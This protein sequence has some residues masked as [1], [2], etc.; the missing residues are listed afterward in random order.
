MRRSK[1]EIIR[2]IEEIL[3]NGKSFDRPR[4]KILL[5]NK[6]PFQVQACPWSGKT[7]L[8]VAKLMFLA[9]TL[10][11]SKERICVLTHTNIAVD[12]IKKKIEKHRNKPW[13][14]EFINNVYKLFDYPNH[15]GTIQVFL[16]K[17]LWIPWY[18]KKYWFRPNAIDD[19]RIKAYLTKR[20]EHSTF[21]NKNPNKKENIINANFDIFSLSFDRD[22]NIKPSAITYK[23]LI[24]TKKQQIEEYRYL[25]FKEIDY[26]SLKY[27]QESENIKS[28]LQNRFKYVFLDEIQDTHSLHTQI[29]NTL[30]EWWNNIIQWFWDYNQE[31]FNSD[32][33]EKWEFI[34]FWRVENQI[35]NSLRLSSTI[36]ENV[37]NVSIKPQE[38]KW[39]TWRDIPI[40]FII[41]ERNNTEKV[42]DKFIEIICKYEQE[43]LDIK[44]DDL[45]FKAV[46]WIGKD[47]EEWKLNIQSYWKKYNNWKVSKSKTSLFSYFQKIDFKDFKN[48]WYVLYK[49]NIVNGILHAF[50]Y[51]KDNQIL[52]DYTDKKSGQI[53]K[54]HFSKTTFLE[55]LKQNDLHSEFQRNIYEFSRQIQSDILDWDN[56]RRYM[57]LLEIDWKK[58]KD[59]DFFQKYAIPI[60]I[61]NVSKDN[62]Y[63]DKGFKIWDR[64]TTIQFA[65]IAKVKWETHTWTLVLDTTYSSETTNRILQFWEKEKEYT[66]WWDIAK[67]LTNYY[68]AITRATHLLCIAICKDNWKEDKKWSRKPEKEWEIIFDEELCS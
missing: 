23:R 55:Y 17:Y 1:K 62:R 18:E 47:K 49:E 37:K 38:L 7:T 31:I 66:K 53:K 2:K 54:K 22:I 21:L 32:R 40:Y 11:F 10:D 67:S 9:Q 24:A 4:R 29:L 19:D 30:Y 39:I 27:L 41:F 59:W 26:F 3:L 28:L 45:I 44:E 15:I 46:W 33:A 14:R 61:P 5:D 48:S 65:T 6:N 60:W 16:N 56:V 25:K 8:L 51:D 12:E 68:V 57:L 58:I 13:Y 50:N 20:L 64:E 52:F 63:P 43:F 36:A 42:V 34:I 35:N